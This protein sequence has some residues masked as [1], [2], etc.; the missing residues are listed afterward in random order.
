MLDMMVLKNLQ[1][2]DKICFQAIS[3]IFIS[4]VK[5]DL[6]M[7]KPHNVKLNFSDPHP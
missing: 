6:I 4:Q 2:V 3:M 1:K 7:L 5:I